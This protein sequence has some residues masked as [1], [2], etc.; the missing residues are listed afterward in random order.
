MKIK[1]V[2]DDK[3]LIE[4]YS[5]S[6]DYIEKGIIIKERYI[7]DVR[8]NIG[9]VLAIGDKVKNIEVGDMLL[10]AVG[11]YYTKFKLNSD[12]EKELIIIPST[13]AILVLK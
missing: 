12:D 3:I 11:S 10:Y 9:K 4:W 7:R 8:S 6:E 5:F 1:K 13:D 2:I